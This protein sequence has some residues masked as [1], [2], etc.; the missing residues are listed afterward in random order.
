MPEL[1]DGGAVSAG[2]P[3]P[4]VPPPWA[5]AAPVF[6]R[7]SLASGEQVLFETRPNHVAF[8]LAASL[9][10]ILWIFF[11]LFFFPFQIAFTATAAGWELFCLGP[12][13]LLVFVFLIGLFVRHLRWTKT[14]YAITT[15]RVMSTTG[16]IGRTHVECPHD[17]IQNVTLRQGV[18]ERLLGCGT[19]VFATAGIGGGAGGGGWGWGWGGAQRGPFAGGDVVFLAVDD[20]VGTKRAVDELLERSRV[21]RR[22]RELQELAS[23]VGARGPQPIFCS[24]CGSRLVPGAAACGNCG[25]AVSA[26]AGR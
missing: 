2:P 19:L 18:L 22:Q 24:F 6:P 9:T 21:A 13:L 16:L 20:P 14:A 10:S 7:E 12:I 25:A 8:L 26:A 4:P 5:A 11:L 17:R 1:R 3:P 23:A 15:R